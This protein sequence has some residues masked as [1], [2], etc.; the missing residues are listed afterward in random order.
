ME[1]GDV[2]RLHGLEK[3]VKFISDHPRVPGGGF[4]SRGLL[5]GCFPG[6]ICLIIIFGGFLS[7]RR[8]P[9]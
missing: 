2:V 9:S 5:P 7:H 3:A 1:V 6:D 4:Q 8:A